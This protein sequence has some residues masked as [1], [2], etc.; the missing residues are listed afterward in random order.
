[1]AQT[2]FL[3][4]RSRGPRWNDSVS[5]E[6]QDQWPAHADFMDALNAEGF[7]ALV[8]PVEGT[9]YALLLVHAQ[10]EDQIHQRL[11]EDPWSH[12]GLL[13]TTEVRRWTLRLGTV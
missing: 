7:L 10:N 12:N 2:V 4:T 8:G 1:M 3:V 5:M 11:S 9:R 13:Q 6:Q